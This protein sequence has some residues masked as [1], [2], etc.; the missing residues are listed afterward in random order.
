VGMEAAQLQQFLVFHARDRPKRCK[1]ARPAPGQFFVFMRY[2]LMRGE[3]GAHSLASAAAIWTF[4][5]FDDASS[6]PSKGPLERLRF[7]E[8]VATRR[9]V[10]MT[11][12]LNA[13]S[14][15]WDFRIPRPM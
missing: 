3:W 10:T 7:G 6:S 12:A 2:V 14:D 4:A 9:S 8:R 5:A 15:S 13:S 1:G 11:F